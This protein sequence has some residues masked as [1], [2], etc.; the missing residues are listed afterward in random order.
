MGNRPNEL[1]L[2]RDGNGDREWFG[3]STETCEVIG[4]RRGPFP[5]T[6]AETLP[7]AGEGLTLHVGQSLQRGW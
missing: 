4:L 6:S 1:A 2:L 7:W 3:W 5:V